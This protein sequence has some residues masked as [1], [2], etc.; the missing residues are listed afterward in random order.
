MLS[1]QLVDD[2]QQLQEHYIV[3]KVVMISGFVC[4]FHL[5][6]CSSRYELSLNQ[7]KQL[8]DTGKQ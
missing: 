3:I 5:A 6:I 4:I 2:W 8:G 1:R 7:L